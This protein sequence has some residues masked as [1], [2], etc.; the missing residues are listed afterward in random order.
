VPARRPLF[1]AVFFDGERRHHVASPHFC[2]SDIL[3]CFTLKGQDDLCILNVQDDLSILNGQD[4]FSLV[5][6]EG[7]DE[8]SHRP[9]TD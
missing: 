1:E 4:I 6:I 2:K 8:F 5:L 9:Q 3:S 7:Q